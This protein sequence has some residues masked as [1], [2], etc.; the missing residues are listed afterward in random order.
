MSDHALSS[1]A[2]TPLEPP[3]TAKPRASRRL[4][5]VAVCFAYRLATGLLI[6]L[7]LAALLTSAVANQPRGD[8]V[9]WDPGA[10]MLIE[11]LRLA[12]RGAVGAISAS[13]VLTLVVAFLG[14]LPFAALIAGLG[15]EG[16]LPAGYLAARAIAPMGTLALLWGAGLVVQVVLAGLVVL[17]GAKVVALFHLTVPGEDIGRVVLLAVALLAVIAVGVVRDLAAVSAVNDGSRLYTSA[18]RAVRVAIEAPGRVAMAY[19]SRGIPAALAIAVAAGLAASLK[20]ADSHPVVLPFFL[21]Q[22]ALALTVFLHAS[23]LAAAIRLLDQFAPIP[24]S[25]LAAEEPE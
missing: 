15:R 1:I 19:A 12:G 2:Q 25:P 4:G 10:I 16:R 6:A 3:R 18:A 13:S 9:L 7:P 14:L 5:L 24:G 21:H 17:I 8:A 22:G 23:W 11:A 20:S